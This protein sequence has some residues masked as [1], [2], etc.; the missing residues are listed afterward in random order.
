MRNSADGLPRTDTRDHD[1]FGNS[2]SSKFKTQIRFVLFRS[3]VIF[4]TTLSLNG[5]VPTPI[6]ITAVGLRMA[7]P[8]QISALEASPSWQT[9][10]SRTVRWKVHPRRTELH[11]PHSHCLFPFSG[12][13]HFSGSLKNRIKAT[14]SPLI[15]R[16]LCPGSI[17]STLSLLF[18]LSPLLSMEDSG[19][20]G[21]AVLSPFHQGRRAY[22]SLGMC[23][24]SLAGFLCGKGPWSSVDGTVSS[25]LL[26]P[27][28]GYHLIDS[29]RYRRPV[30]E[31]LRE[32]HDHIEHH[33]VHIRSSGQT[34]QN[35]L[36]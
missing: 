33:Q 5:G 8:C 14:M 2:F 16:L 4:R 22:L 28:G 11:L 12:T 24:T 23:S 36:R 1:L 35:I 20:G 15:R 34:V 13:A 31:P 26:P 30:L 27:P 6:A 10:P 18:F 17:F 29:R 9:S 25:H 7:A 21:E 32:G 19:I 3:S